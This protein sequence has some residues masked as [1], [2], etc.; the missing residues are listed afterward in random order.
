[1]SDVFDMDVNYP[2]KSFEIKPLHDIDQL[3]A[4][5]YDIQPLSKMRRILNS[6]FVSG[7]TVPFFLTS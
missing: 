4:A 3:Q 5:E 6:V 2:V 7:T 1:M